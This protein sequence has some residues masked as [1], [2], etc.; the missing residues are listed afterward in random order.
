MFEEEATASLSAAQETSRRLML[1]PGKTGF[2]TSPLQLP[3][4]WGCSLVKCGATQLT[5]VTCLILPLTTAKMVVKN[6]TGLLRK[7]DSALHFK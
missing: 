7:E 6:V 5:M 1:S 2:H 3:T 4:G